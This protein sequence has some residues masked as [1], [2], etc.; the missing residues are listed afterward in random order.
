[1]K[2]VIL[3]GGLGTRISEETTVKPKPMVEIGGMPIIWHIM[4]IYSNFGFKDFV[5]CLGYKGYVIKEFFANYRRHTSDLTIDLKNNNITI[6]NSNT[7]DW[8]VSLVETGA[9]AMTGARIKKIKKYVQDDEGFCLT[10][11]DGVSN[12]NI[13]ELVDFHKSHKKIATLTAV[14]SP[15]RFGV[16]NIDDNNNGIVDSFKEKPEEAKDWINGGFFVLS[17]KVFDYIGDGD[18]VVFEQNPLQGLTK[19]GQLMS[20][21]H[22]GFWHAMDSLRDKMNLDQMASHSDIPP[23]MK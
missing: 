15:S 6:D 22:H 3:A 1:M 23:W 21:K 13:K 20:F 18:D 10:Y 14:K 17:N 19:D 2:V 8:T 16:L 9:N 11:G 5:I 7:E 4:K 12:V